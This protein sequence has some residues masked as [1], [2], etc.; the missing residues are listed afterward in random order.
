MSAVVIR[1]EAAGR[2]Q[3]HTRAQ[4]YA[5]GTA[6]I[7]LPKIDTDTASR[8]RLVEHIEELEWILS[9]ILPDQ[10]AIESIRDAFGITRQQSA[11]LA[12]LAGGRVVSN[13][14]LALT[15][16]RFED[17]LATSTI[18]AQV[19]KLRKRTAHLGINVKVVWGVGYQLDAA[20][21]PLVQSVINGEG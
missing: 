15:V 11:I 6:Q 21:V 18:K 4:P 12:A 5:G 19:C 10:P 3:G 8:D 9:S 7:K 2:E 1:M 13:E 17:E 20:S 16:G 14:H